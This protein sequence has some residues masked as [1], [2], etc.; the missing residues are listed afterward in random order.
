MKRLFFSCLVALFA[1]NAIADEDYNARFNT[2]LKDSFPLAKEILAEWDLKGPKDGDYYAAHFNIHNNQALKFIVA[3]DKY[4]PLYAN[5]DELMPMRDSLGN[6]VGYIR[7]NIDLENPE[8]LDSAITWIKKGIE[9]CPQRLDLRIGYSTL[10]RMLDDAEKMYSIMEQTVNWV[11][12]NPN[13]QLTWTSDQAIDKESVIS[14]SMQDY[15][16][17]CYYSTAH[18]DHAEKFADL[19]LRFSPN[20][21]VFWNDK[22]VLKL[23]KDDLQGA[24]E[25]MEKALTFNPDDDL[26][27]E[28]IKHI[29]NM[30][31]EKEEEEKKKEK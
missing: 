2:A 5:I 10:Y 15:F 3:I 13:T 17:N 28:N 26:I 29:K 4:V 19:G 22:A 20:S 8:E 11:L 24:L 6:E 14:D 30:I 27:K 7:Q 21:A 9:K 12:A 31:K 1:L 16:S 18:K 25:L 23:D